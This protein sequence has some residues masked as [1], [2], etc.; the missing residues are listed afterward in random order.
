MAH[1]HATGEGTI[2]LRKDGRWEAAIKVP[3]T[4]GTRIRKRVYGATRAEAD[5]KL[6]E[7]KAQVQRGIPI[8]EKTWR[9][10]PYLDYWLEQVV[11]PAR[12][13][14]TYEKYDLVVR[15]YLKPALG[16]YMLPQ[17][18]VTTLQGFFNQLHAKGGSVANLHKVR[19]VLSSALTK[20]MKEELVATNVAR[21]V[22]LPSY[23]RKR[24]DPW[25]I[26]EATRFM[27]V[28]TGE[29]LYPAF[30][31]ALLYGLRRGEVLGL[32]WSDIDF[33]NGILHIRQQLQR[34]GGALFV[35]PVKTEASERDLQLRPIP[36]D[37]L[38]RQRSLQDTL[39][40]EAGDAWQGY[41]EVEAL[42]FTTS[43]GKPTDPRNYARSFERTCKRYGLRRI[44]P[45]DMRHT[46]AT[47]A[48]LLELSPK[49]VQFTLGHSE[50]S[51]TI[52]VYQHASIASSD[53]VAGAV[54]SVLFSSN[55]E[56]G[57][58][59]VAVSRGTS[60]SSRQS[61][62]SNGNFARYLGGTFGQLPLEPPIG[63]EPMTPALRKIP[64]AAFGE[65]ITSVNA[66]L[67]VRRYCWILGIV[68]VKCGRQNP[69]PHYPDV[70]RP[71][72]RPTTA[73]HTLRCMPQ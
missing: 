51:T 13:P 58:P 20:A 69:S 49:D 29:P 3:T 27:S 62:P 10:G 24:I 23:R 48:S 21:L 12:Q 59:R 64:G 33:D 28:A 44:R 46:V 22:D 26:E 6:T 19:T 25:S 32:R 16:S 5:A 71:A 11:L 43:S 9:L 30:A 45:H 61:V 17:L 68:A 52:G 1:A 70:S 14:G 4:A 41:R 34:R 72:L 8:P 15:R 47:I 18:R 67:R 66:I 65:Y 54:E 53:R 35:G 40:I 63:F 56:N 2:Y 7:L 55:N 36:R 31:I 42:V 73:V 57:S 38:L 37:L 60:G 39:R 50:V